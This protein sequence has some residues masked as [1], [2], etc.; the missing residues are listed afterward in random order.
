VEENKRSGYKILDKIL[1]IQ[2]RNEGY[3]YAKVSS[4]SISMLAG[5]LKKRSTNAKLEKLV[6]AP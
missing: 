2:Y 1:P 5:K 3:I 4:A 6:C